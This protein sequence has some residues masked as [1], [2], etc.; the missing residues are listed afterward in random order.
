VFKEDGDSW[1]YNSANQYKF[2]VGA[3]N[4]CT[5][6]MVLPSWILTNPNNLTSTPIAIGTGNIK[7]D[8]NGN[9]SNPYPI[10]INQNFNQVLGSNGQKYPMVLKDYLSTLAPTQTNKGIAFSIDPA[11]IIA[12]NTIDQTGVTYAN[13]MKIIR[14]VLSDW[15]CALGMNITI[16][17]NADNIISAGTMQAIMGYAPYNFKPVSGGNPSSDAATVIDASGYAYFK[18]CW[19]QINTDYLAQFDFNLPGKACTNTYSFYL[20]LAH[21][22]GHALNLRHVNIPADL[23]YWQDNETASPGQLEGLS[24][25]TNSV[26]A[27]QYMENLSKTKSFLTVPSASYCYPVNQPLTFKTMAIDPWDIYLSW[28]NN[29]SSTDATDPPFYTIER[30]TDGVNYTPYLTTTS[31]SYTDGIAA[32]GAASPVS[33]NTTY[34]YRIKECNSM[35]SSPWVLANATTPPEAVPPTPTSPSTGYLFGE[36]VINWA[37]NTSQTT[38]YI[39]LRSTTYNGTYTQVGSVSPASATTFTDYSASKNTTYFYE[40]KAVNSTY[41]SAPS[42]QTGVFYINCN[43]STL[44]VITLPTYDAQNPVQYGILTASVSYPLL[45]KQY[46]VVEAGNVVHITPGFKAMRG[47][48]FHAAIAT[49]GSLKSEVLDTATATTDVKKTPISTTADRD[50]VTTAVKSGIVIYP[51]PTQ[52]IIMIETTKGATFSIELFSSLG[53]LI[54]QE[55]V[56]SNQTQLDMSGYTSG[57]YYLKVKTKLEE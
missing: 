8:A 43:N 52:G 7:I 16:D 34:Y 35:G 26:T 45:P 42:S 28:S 12:V 21:E 44:N 54:K 14:R 22:I 33:P 40:I 48:L 57:T 17:P 4:L 38:G 6:Q 13:M 27:A 20:T 39:I 25:F 18:R 36:P 37:A 5:M 2:T 15:S 51:N 55:Q 9:F 47:S 10:S 41:T 24:Y 49:C 56:S 3:N 46:G 29:P 53:V 31:L 23:M 50:S 30:S 11:A 19:I 32:Y 1:D